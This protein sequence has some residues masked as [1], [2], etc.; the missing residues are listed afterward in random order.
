MDPAI[1][2][3]RFIRFRHAT[4]HR[5]LHVDAYDLVQNLLFQDGALGFRTRQHDEY[6]KTGTGCFTVG[7]AATGE[8][9][10]DPDEIRMVRQFGR[11]RQIA[12]QTPVQ[13]EIG[14]PAFPV[15]FN[16]MA[17]DRPQQPG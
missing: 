4:D 13:L 7:I 16:I 6:I 15:L 10:E 8:P 11:M 2:Y 9:A 5:H 3:V 14:D 17:A 12:G 1:E